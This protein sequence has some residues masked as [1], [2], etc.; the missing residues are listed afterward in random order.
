MKRSKA[1]KKLIISKDDLGYTEEEEINGICEV[2]PGTTIAQF[3]FSNPL[4]ESNFTILES[5]KVE[6]KKSDVIV[7]S[8]N[9]SS[10]IVDNR[11]LK[12]SA[13]GITP[14]VDGEYFDVSRTFKFRKSTI[15]M[16]NELKAAHP[17]INI[18]L[19]SIVD[20]ALRHYYSYIFG[21][22]GSH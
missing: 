11:T 12:T 5:K 10:H 20:N 9:L 19:S 4:T 2:P 1:A 18:Y 14:P 6:E 16:L 3:N 7:N 22:K 21:E 8:I 13:N 15:K 17:D